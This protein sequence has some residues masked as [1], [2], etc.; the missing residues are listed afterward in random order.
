MTLGRIT[1]YIFVE[2]WFEKRRRL[3][4][5]KVLIVNDSGFERMVLRDQ[6][7]M[8]GYEVKTADE[9]TSLTMIR[10]FHPDIVIANLTMTDISGDKLIAHIKSIDPNIR[11]F[12]SSCSKIDW[13]TVNSSLIEGVIETPVVKA[14]L[15]TILNNPGLGK[16]KTEYTPSLQD[17]KDLL[18][19]TNRKTNAPLIPTATLKIC[20]SCSKESEKTE[21]DFVFCPF[22]GTRLE[23]YFP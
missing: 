20:P 22:C 7:R 18:T 2:I 9:I 8:L 6:I 5:K 13:R 4:I 1:V 3:N 10:G 15:E 17:E 11:C 23:A 21:C 14:T 19:V 16:N 12:L